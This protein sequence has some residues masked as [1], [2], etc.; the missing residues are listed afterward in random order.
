MLLE[1]NDARAF[2]INGWSPVYLPFYADNRRLHIR[3][4]SS[5]AAKLRDISDDMQASI[6]TVGIIV[7]AAS[8]TLSATWFDYE[9]GP[10]INYVSNAT[11]CLQTFVE[12]ITERLRRLDGK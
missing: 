8:L 9:H 5:Q 7:L 11:K 12:T 3:L 2:R 4:L 10:R 6:G 1:D